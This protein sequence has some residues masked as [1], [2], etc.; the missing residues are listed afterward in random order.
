MRTFACEVAP[1]TTSGNNPRRVRDLEAA[2]QSARAEIARLRRG[3][4]DAPE[5]ASEVVDAQKLCARAPGFGG[6]WTQVRNN[7][8]LAPRLPRVAPGP[9]SVITGG[10]NR[11]VR[12]V[13]RA[14]AF[15]GG[16]VLVQAE[17]LQARTSTR[18]LVGASL[19][20]VDLNGL[21]A[22]AKAESGRRRRPRRPRT[23]AA[24]ADD[25]RQG[26]PASRRQAPARAPSTSASRR[27]RAPA[28][29][30]TRCHR[31]VPP[32]PRLP[33]TALAGR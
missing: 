9:A 23:S 8:G 13:A 6:R 11:S 20:N 18:P 4:A 19:A 30:R 2:L 27:R 31:R 32:G 26:G 14:R 29:A 12:R 17:V 22:P 5:D 33:R 21:A 1:E 25:G 24:V 10:F 15:D 7:A 3:S 16:S 28:R